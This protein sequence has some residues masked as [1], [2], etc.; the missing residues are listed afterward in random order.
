LTPLK[1]YYSAFRPVARS[2]SLHIRS[3]RLE[4]VPH[5]Q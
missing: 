5:D 3:I 2:S 4:R 1:T